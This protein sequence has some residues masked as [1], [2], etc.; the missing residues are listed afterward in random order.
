MNQCCSKN[1]EKRSKRPGDSATR[2]D[3]GSDY[4][5]QPKLNGNGKV[6]AQYSMGAAVPLAAPVQTKVTMGTPGDRYEREADDVADRVS[7]GRSAGEISTLPP[8]GLRSQSK[9]EPEAA[10]ELVQREPVDG[11]EQESV[12]DESGQESVA[13]REASGD[14]SGDESAQGKCESCEGNEAQSAST[15]AENAQ[16]ASVQMESE[17]PA[18]AKSDAEPEAAAQSEDDA[19]SASTAN[20]EGDA[21]M[22]GGEETQEASEAPDESAAQTADDGGGE[23]EAGGAAQESAQMQEEGGSDQESGGGDAQM[24]DDAGGDSDA[25]TAED[26]SG[27]TENLDA[28]EERDEGQTEAPGQEMPCES[29]TEGGGDEGASESGGGESEG[30]GAQNAEGEE[31]PADGGEGGEEAAESAA[32]EAGETQEAESEGSGEEQQECGAAQTAAEDSE[33]AAQMQSE[34]GSEPDAGQPAEDDT[35]AQEQSVQMEAA[36]SEAQGADEPAQEESEDA[37]AKSADEPAQEESE[38]AEAKSGDESAQEESEEAETKSVDE[39]AQEESEEAEAKSNDESAQEESEDA[40][41]EQEDEAAQGKAMPQPN[42]SNKRRRSALAASAIQNRG[43]GEPLTPETRSSLESSMGVDLGD[44]RVHTDSRARETN[45][46]LRAKAFTNKNHVYLGPGQSQSNVRLMA[47]EVT[48]VVQQGGVDRSKKA[49]ISSTPDRAEPAGAGTQSVAPAATDAEATAPKSATGPAPAGPQ[50]AATTDPLTGEAIGRVEDAP[51]AASAKGAEKRPA[52]AGGGAP[53][54]AAAPAGEGGKPEA[55]EKGDGKDKKAAK[56]GK[57]KSGG[58]E[59][60]AEQADVPISPEGDPRYQGVMKRLDRVAKKER[61]HEPAKAKAAEVKM[62]VKPPENERSSQ[63]QAIKVGDMAA[64]SA[65]AEPP[66]KKGFRELL[67]EKLEDIVPEKLEEV[68]DFK[69]SGKAKTLKADIAK[70]VKER[71]EASTQGLKK[72]SDAQPPTSKV[73]EKEVKALPEQKRERWPGGIGAANVLPL[74]KKSHEISAEDNK[75]SADQLMAEND[76]DEDQLK[77]AKEPRFTEALEAKKKLDEHADSVPEKYRETENAY[78]P[79]EKDAATADEKTGKRQLRGTRLSSKSKVRKSQTKAQEKEEKERASVASTIEGMYTETKGK[80]DNNLKPLDKEVTDMFDKDETRARSLFENY[81]DFK[82]KEYKRKR[83]SSFGGGAKWLWDKVAGLPDSV[84]KFYEEGKD[85]YLKL[86]GHAIDRIVT[87]VEK[88]LAKARKDIKEGRKTID[89]FV[90]TLKGNLK[91]YGKEIQGDVNAKFDELEDSVENKKE[92]LANNLA[93]KYKQSR[94]K[95]DDRIKELKAQNKGLWDKFKALVKEIIEV[96]RKFKEA[97]VAIFNMAGNILRLII[98]HPDS[99]LGNLLKA[100]K[101]GFNQFKTHFVKHLKAGFMSWLFGQMSKANIAMPSEFSF[102]AL[103][104]VILNIIGITKDWIRKRITQLIG[105]KNV[106]RI[107]K[108]WGVI[109]TVI[110]SGV[111]G[112]WAKAKEFLTGLKKKLFGDIKDWLVTQIVKQGVIWVVSLFNP[113]AALLKVIKMIYDVVMFFVENIDRI[114]RLVQTILK[115]TQKIVAGQIGAAA[116]WIE[117]AM[118]STIP[119]IIG[120]LAKILG[121]SGI[122]KRIQRFIKSVRRR[123]RRA[124]DKVLK[125][126]VKGAKKLLRGG[127]TLAAKGKKAVKA[128][129]KKIAK[130]LFPK[131]RFSA[132]GEKHT[133]EAVPSGRKHKIIVRSYPRSVPKFIAWARSENKQKPNP[134]VE[135]ALKKLEARYAKWVPMKVESDASADKVGSKSRAKNKEYL[136]IYKDV[137][138]IIE[139]LQKDGD[140][141]VSRVT[142]GGIDSRGRATSVEADPLTVKGALGSRPSNRIPGWKMGPESQIRAHLLHDRLHGPGKRFNL[143]PTSRSINGQMYHRAE[144]PALRSLGIRKGIPKNEQFEQLKFKTEVEYGDDSTPPTLIDAAKTI[145][146]NVEGRDPKTNKLTPIVTNWKGYNYP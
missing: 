121:V 134:K 23:Q 143:T 4:D 135:P 70:N 42:R 5:V 16:P 47:H 95:L 115:A 14:E 78:L 20:A 60:D 139:M 103:F 68:D 7:G 45:R 102:K 55:G 46:G 142:W 104:G 36:D 25:E 144:K 89:G 8:G 31:E 33:G 71:K 28:G 80:V 74:P 140:P 126:I 53:S 1:S 57:G 117:K 105:A 114:R 90:K 10:Q 64:E 58:S 2:H 137:R 87:T 111:G 72:A 62:A 59:G 94:K 26:S 39:S 15:E 43:A 93:R 21:Q 22:E 141:P 122:G 81:V 77:R 110:S 48:H 91:T 9:E 97:I 138:D 131:K 24:E 29:A 52:A 146:V 120:F 50:A 6:G 17:E 67:E 129:G 75:K 13:Q 35:A 82:M 37:E 30:C 41:E 113:V 63:A 19:E 133:V 100:V 130:L 132:G 11:A 85:I 86:M 136:N 32:E 12:E 61:A 66:K 125:K 54:D 124:V 116:N 99:F 27:Q 79:G 108:A 128:A 92:G 44:V 69:K 76:I 123:V 145:T 56:G 119:M 118:A 106:A 18:E 49:S 84:N 73:P 88:R 83:Y 40:Q 34:N 96:L 109:S 38:D 3:R 98:K 112:L 101:K 107:E 65:A 127:K 51:D